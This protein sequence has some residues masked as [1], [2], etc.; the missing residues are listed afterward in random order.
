MNKSITP[1]PPANFTQD[2]GEYRP[3]SPFRQWCQKVLPLVYDDSLSYY[4]LLCKVVD[5]LNKTMEDVETLHGDVTNLHEA[6]IKLQDYV[7]NYFSSLDVQE[8]IN[9][10]LDEMFE[11]G[12]F[13]DIINDHLT[14]GFINV[15]SKG[16]KKDGVTPTAK[17]IN[18]IINEFTNATFYFPPGVYLLE[19]PLELYND[20]I[21]ALFF[22]GA[23][24][25]C[26]NNDSAIKIITKTSTN[27]KHPPKIYGTGSIDMNNIAKTGINVANESRYLK[28][29]D[30]NIENI[31]DGIGIQLGTGKGASMSTFLENICVRGTSSEN[32]NSIGVLAIGYDNYF[33]NVNIIRCY[34]GIR[35]LSG[36]NML[37]NVHVWSDLQPTNDNWPK[38]YGIYNGFIDNMI[39]NIYLDNCAVGIW[40]L[41][42]TICSNIFYYL[43]YESSNKTAVIFRC[44]QNNLVK[45]TGLYCVKKD[46]YITNVLLISNRTQEYQV[47]SGRGFLI[48]SNIIDVT[49]FEL[50]SEAFNI[51]N[52]KFSSTLAKNVQN[53]IYAETMYLLGYLTKTTGV[54]TLTINYGGAFCY[55]ITI[56]SERIKDITSDDV[57]AELI[58]GLSSSGKEK[59]IF[60]VPSKVSEIICYPVYMQFQNGFSGSLGVDYDCVGEGGFYLNSHLNVSDC[61]FTGVVNELLSIDL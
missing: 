48:D 7:N 54:S 2:M 16:A 9:N 20:N 22:D 45:C 31:G 41:Q 24:L 29:T 33:T 60:G 5:Y 37:N 25:L 46:G 50:V 14:T 10:K 36:G 23:T 53:N 13:D 12:L 15:V 28:I 34:G 3:L 49:G 27:E 59:I 1:L 44:A 40:C 26:D 55:K 18:N 32:I 51:R 6:F 58:S 43:P 19:E 11:Q 56:K 52:N 39:N 57:K 30:I 4:E 21:W 61:A 17:I 35:L 47:T 8:E 38:S 42:P